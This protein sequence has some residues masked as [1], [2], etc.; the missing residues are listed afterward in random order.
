M[1]EVGIFSFGRRRSQRCPNKMLRRFGDT[2]LTDIVLS[3]L[4]VLSRRGHDVFFAG[5]EREFRVKCQHHGVPFV[6]RDR[7][8]VLIDRPIVD[9]LS[10]LRTV[11]YEYLLLVNA[12]LPFLR[13]RTIEAFLD[14]CNANGRRPA[15]GVTKRT[16]YFVRLDGRAINFDPAEKTI[17]TKTVTPVYEFA[18]ALYFFRRRYLL[19][20][21][22]YWNWRSVRSIELPDRRELVDIDTED[23]FA[24]AEALWKVR[25]R[26]LVGYSPVTARRARD[27]GDGQ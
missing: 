22:T 24:F 11:S 2:T 27:S 23:D 8:S 6:R 14:D 13:T 20:H 19:E 9:I 3:K 1:S 7:T 12:C 18:H 17:N 10:F 21:G 15:F 26:S 5:Y 4:S 25:R 16:N